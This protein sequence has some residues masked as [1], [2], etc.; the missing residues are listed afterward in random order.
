MQTQLRPGT[1]GTLY[2]NPPP[3]LPAVARTAAAP[4]N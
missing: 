1:W 3:H 2:L 4:L